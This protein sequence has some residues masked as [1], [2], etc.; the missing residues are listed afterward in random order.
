M[1]KKSQASG[2]SAATL[3]AIIAGL[4]VLYVLFI[5][6]SE[7]E[8]ILEDG[9]DSNGDSDD[10]GEN[11][12]IL[13]ETP[14]RLEPQGID[15]VEHNIPSMN[16]RI[17]EEASVLKTREN[18]DVRRALFRDE[19]EN[20]SFQISNLEDT[21]DVLLSFTVDSKQ[22]SGNL[23]I[24][25]NGQEVYD[26]EIAATNIPPISLE[27]YLQENNDLEFSV[28][29]PG[30]LFWRT[31]KYALEDVKITANIIQREAQESRSTFIVKEFEKDNAERVKIKFVPLCEQEI[32]KKLNVWL[33]NY[34]L[35]SAVPECR[36]SVNLEASPDYL[37]E[38]ENTLRFKTEGGYYT[39]EQI[40]VLTDLKEI[41]YPIYYFQLD[42]DEYSDIADK[43]KDIWIKIRFAEADSEK[44]GKVIINGNKQHIMQEEIS[45]TLDIS[46]FV[47]QGNN[48][49]KIE[50]EETMDIAQLEVVLEE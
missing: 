11:I 42:S 43:E 34:Q 1:R 40:R 19:K 45:Y 39:I 5:P 8:A 38:G 41:E 7:R 14:G 9:D 12:S 23:M 49:V 27:G 18:L 33:N 44:E 22:G 35:Y 21:E 2:A 16:L 6:P 15:Q 4:I 26:N 28:S 13:L 25:L 29:S 17:Q 10:D 47:E 46:E 36:L 32:V 48:A 37:V 20:V 24:N 31:N 30:A 50:P 3:V